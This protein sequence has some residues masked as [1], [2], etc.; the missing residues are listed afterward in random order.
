MFGG[1][2]GALLAGLDRSRVVIPGSGSQLPVA[3]PRCEVTLRWLGDR[4]ARNTDG[5]IGARIRDLLTLMTAR[6]NALDR[7]RRDLRL[8]AWLDIWL[9]VHI[10][11][12]FAL[13]AAL[14]A[15]VVSVFVYW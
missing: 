4:L 1:S 9:Y 6:R 2:V 7:L 14:T 12:A 3:N 15:H 8:Q 13:L 10:P 5:R 11:L